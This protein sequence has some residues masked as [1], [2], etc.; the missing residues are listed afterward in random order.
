[1]RFYPA[2]LPFTFLAVFSL[3]LP[4]EFQVYFSVYF[5]FFLFFWRSFNE[6]SVARKAKRDLLDFPP[7]YQTSYSKK[8]KKK[9]GTAPVDRIWDW[10]GFQMKRSRERRSSRGNK[11]L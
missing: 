2:S 6:E 9:Y 7:L 1:M 8:T 3:S 11:E 5:A 10:I 4:F